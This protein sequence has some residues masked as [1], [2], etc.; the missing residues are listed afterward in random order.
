M[1]SACTT[2]WMLTIGLPFYPACLVQA[3]TYSAAVRLAASGNY[4]RDQDSH[5]E[6]DKCCN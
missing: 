2:V 6:W 4:E 5:C 3:G 1:V